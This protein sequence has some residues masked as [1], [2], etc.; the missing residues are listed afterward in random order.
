MDPASS[1]DGTT[2]LRRPGHLGTRRGRGRRSAARSVRR[3]WTGPRCEGTPLPGELTMRS[4]AVRH[5]PV[6]SDGLFPPDL[7]TG[8]RPDL[9]RCWRH[10]SPRSWGTSADRAARPSP[11]DPAPGATRSRA[12]RRR[13]PNGVRGNRGIDRRR[14]VPRSHI[15]V[16][17]TE[18]VHDMRCRFVMTSWARQHTIVSRSVADGLRPRPASARA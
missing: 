17:A 4:G 10:E 5:G 11:L 14:S 7:R 13:S 2:L 1:P 6:R 16:A 12:R 3:W 8:R 18:W 15:P 9:R